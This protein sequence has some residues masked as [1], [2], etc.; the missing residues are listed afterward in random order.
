MKDD[1]KSSQSGDRRVHAEKAEAEASEA[2]QLSSG[3]VLDAQVTEHAQPR[4]SPQE[5]WGRR[6]CLLP[7]SLHENMLAGLE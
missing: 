1:E 3:I 7:S 4:G 2:S 5:S 6:P